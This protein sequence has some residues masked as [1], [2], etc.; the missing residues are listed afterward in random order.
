M[1]ESYIRDYYAVNYGSQGVI[2]LIMSR[3]TIWEMNAL[4]MTTI[5]LMIMIV[6]IVIPLVFN[7][8]L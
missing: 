8:T 4:T 7:C 2:R 6:I 3:Q 5:I 1:V